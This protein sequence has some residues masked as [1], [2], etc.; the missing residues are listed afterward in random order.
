MEEPD[1]LV[2]EPR[3]PQPSRAL[4]ILVVALVAATLLG[5]TAV[6]VSGRY[7]AAEETAALD[8][9]ATR[10][11]EAA[12]LAESRLGAMVRYVLPA[13]GTV[14][15]ELD[16]D[17]Y[18]L[19]RRQAVGLDQPVAEALDRCRAVELWPASLDRE[20]ARAAYVAFLGAEL[21]RLRAVSGDGRAYYEDYDEVSRLR[22]EAQDALSA[23]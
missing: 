4:R 9:C 2:H 3:S 10:A 22:Q 23:L 8:R 13:L 11:D 16:A 12:R 21:A 6:W 19:I 15:Q 7:R 20:R 17:L 1:V 14:S 18:G 5:A